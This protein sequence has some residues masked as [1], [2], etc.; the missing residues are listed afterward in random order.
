M[1]RRLGEEAVAEL[2]RRGFQVRG[3]SAAHQTK[4]RKTVVELSSL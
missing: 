3:K 1:L 4:G 2:E